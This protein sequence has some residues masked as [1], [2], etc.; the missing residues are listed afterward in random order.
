ML[1]LNLNNPT[2]RRRWRGFKENFKVS[3]LS[4]W[5]HVNYALIRVRIA[6]Q[7]YDGNRTGARY[8]HYGKLMQVIDIDNFYPFFP[9]N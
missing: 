5:T 4:I 2:W 6:H 3:L 7:T 8:V 9:K 1:A